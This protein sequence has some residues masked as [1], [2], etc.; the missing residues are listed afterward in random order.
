MKTNK[1]QVIEKY[2][3]LIE[4]R[5]AGKGAAARQIVEKYWDAK[6]DELAAYRLA[7][8]DLAINDNLVLQVLKDLAIRF[9]AMNTEIKAL[10]G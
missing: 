3:T 7:R 4:A 2:E 9:P 6:A 8:L 1:E 5:L 10:K